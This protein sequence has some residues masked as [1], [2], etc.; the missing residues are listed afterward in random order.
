MFGLA[1]CILLIILFSI[2][3]GISFYRVRGLEFILTIT[4]LFALIYKTLITI[5]S[6][7]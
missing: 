2:G 6:V 7:F 1:F 5:K 4:A 3:V